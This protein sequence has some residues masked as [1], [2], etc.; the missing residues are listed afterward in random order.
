[1]SESTF[2]I[3]PLS[4]EHDKSLRIEFNSGCAP[5]DRYFKEQV[6]QDVRKNTARCYVAI[7]GDVIAGFYTLASAQINL[8]DIPLEI[9]RK[10]PRYDDVPVIRIGR[11]AVDMNFRGK[12]LGTLMLYDACRRTNDGPAGSFALT[13]DSKDETAK[14]FYLHHDFIPLKNHPSTLFFPIANAGFMK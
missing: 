5:L 1:M 10:L 13:V 7:H 8:H 12:K 11:L 4:K 3:V 9:A 14:A 2:R 6:T